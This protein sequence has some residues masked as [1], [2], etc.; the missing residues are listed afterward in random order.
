MLKNF[1]DI[2]STA[3]LLIDFLNHSKF[4]NN[5]QKKDNIN[6]ENLLN[7]HKNLIVFIKINTANR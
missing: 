6:L 5:S 2:H 3:K 1:P 4:L 7:P